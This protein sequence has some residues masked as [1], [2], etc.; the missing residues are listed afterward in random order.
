MLDA[1]G[2]LPE[3]VVSD[4]AM[5]DGIETTPSAA[6]SATSGT[7]GFGGG[8]GT[9]FG[10]SDARQSTPPDAGSESD[11]MDMDD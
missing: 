2:E 5:G 8:L 10:H 1:L 6:V 3:G 7:S 4:A 11:G 9:I